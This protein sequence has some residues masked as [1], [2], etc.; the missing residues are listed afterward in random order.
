M[1]YEHLL[2][3]EGKKTSVHYNTENRKKEIIK[4]GNIKKEEV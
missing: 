4:E 3:G 2:I 1:K